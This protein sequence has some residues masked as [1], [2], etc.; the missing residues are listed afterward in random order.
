MWL[1]APLVENWRGLS[2]TRFLAIA[3]YAFV[4][5]E[6][7]V[8]ERPLSWVDLTV[9]TLGVATAFGKKA[10][11]A[12]IARTTTNVVGVEAHVRQ[13]IADRRQQAADN[14][15]PGAEVA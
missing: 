14:G 7:W 5:Y 3:C 11:L 1:L 9:L 10:F 6:V 15:W 4:G 12:W 2:L 13:E 8:H